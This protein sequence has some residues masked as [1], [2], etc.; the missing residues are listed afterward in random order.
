MKRLTHMMIRVSRSTIAEP[1]KTC[2]LRLKVFAFDD[3]M[4]KGVGC[5]VANIPKCIGF[6]TVSKASNYFVHQNAS[7]GSSCGAG[8]LLRVSMYADASRLVM[9]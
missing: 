1:F 8:A 7:S 2:N 5:F 9:P 6:V 4:F 3:E